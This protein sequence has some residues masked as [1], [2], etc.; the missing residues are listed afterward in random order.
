MIIGGVC[1]GKD[2]GIVYQICYMRSI[3]LN[4]Q[5][6]A[7]TYT[8]G[9]TVCPGTKYY[10]LTLHSFAGNV[11]TFCSYPEKVVVKFILKA[12]NYAVTE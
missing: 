8:Y 3:H 12:K 11:I 1:I 4:A 6:I 5:G 7:S 2:L 10:R 9:R